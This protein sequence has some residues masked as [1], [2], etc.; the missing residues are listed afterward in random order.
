MRLRERKVLRR[1]IA[2]ERVKILLE[3]AD[4]AAASD[5]EMAEG[6]SRLA[7]RMARRH[8]VSIPRMWRWRYCKNCGVILFPGLTARVR[9]RNERMPHVVITCLKC[10]SVR[11]FPY[12]RE[13]KIR[14]SANV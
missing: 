7:L 6:Y 3:M 13:V 10:G 1:R 14:R 2:S 4:A 8:R 12:V 9:I 11:R 5:L